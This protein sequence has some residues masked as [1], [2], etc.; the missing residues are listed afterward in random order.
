MY[1]QYTIICK[2]CSNFQTQ[3]FF[4]I[5]ASDKLTEDQAKDNVLLQHIRDEHHTIKC[6]QCGHRETTR[7]ILWKRNDDGTGI[8]VPIGEFTGTETIADNVVLSK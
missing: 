6:T 1:F 5:G 8:S 3:H 4:V 7:L 2:A